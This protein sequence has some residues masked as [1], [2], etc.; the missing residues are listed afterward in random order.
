[1]LKPQLFIIHFAGG[2]GFSFDFMHTYLEEFQI[3]AIELPGRGMRSNEMLIRDFETAANDIYRQVKNKL[4]S[5]YF[6]IYAHSMGAL[7]ALRG[8]K[9]LEQDKLNPLC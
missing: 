4:S 6:L 8:T 1:M 7:L 2:N 9:M 5:K 3:E